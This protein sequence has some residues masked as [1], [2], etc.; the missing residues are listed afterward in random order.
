[1]A[2]YDQLV[3]V[4][5]GLMNIYFLVTTDFKLSPFFTPATLSFGP[6]QILCKYVVN[7]LHWQSWSGREK[8]PRE[9]WWIR[10]QMSFP[11]HKTAS[12][13]AKQRAVLDWEGQLRKGE[14]MV[15]AEDKA[16]TGWLKQHKHRASQAGLKTQDGLPSDLKL[17]L[18]MVLTHRHKKRLWN[19]SAC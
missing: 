7:K 6:V 15:G 9:K 5:C 19:Y 13:K 14:V 10:C 18:F 16:Y 3:T 17:K 12:V 11:L 1:M 2:D 4:R 8:Y